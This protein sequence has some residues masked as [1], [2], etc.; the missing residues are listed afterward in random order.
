MAEKLGEVLPNLVVMVYVSADAE[1]LNLDDDLMEEMA[2]GIEHEV[3]DVLGSKR[4]LYGDTVAVTVAS[5]I[6][7]RTEELVARLRTEHNEG[8]E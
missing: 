5:G 4:D 7:E 3:R 1:D 8:K 6:P 2:E